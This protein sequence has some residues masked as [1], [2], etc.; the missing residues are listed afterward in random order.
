MLGMVATIYKRK[1]DSFLPK[2]EQNNS[3]SLCNE[4]GSIEKKKNEPRKKKL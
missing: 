3:K 1:G 2:T 4:I